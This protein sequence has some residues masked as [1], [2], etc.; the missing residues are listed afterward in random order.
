MMGH[1]WN[2]PGTY[3]LVLR[4][5][6]PVL[7]RVSRKTFRLGKGI[8]VYTGSAR[9]PGGLGARISRHL[10]KQK[11][12]HWHI[13]HLTQSLHCTILGVVYCVSNRRL[14]SRICR[15]F[16]EDSRFVAMSGFGA[17]DDIE[18]DSHLFLSRS[19]YRSCIR[20][21]ISK[22]KYLLKSHPSLLLV[23]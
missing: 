11:K 15:L 22:Y 8:Y 23:E 6:R 4:L 2:N 5:G 13:D 12:I 14:E 9:N 21:T 20:F 3:S 19:N 17:S 16:S 18:N 7:I 10:S 1:L